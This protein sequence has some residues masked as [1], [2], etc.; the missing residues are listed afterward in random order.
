MMMMDWPEFFILD[1]GHGNCTILRD[2]AGTVIIDCPSDSTLMATLRYLNIHEIANILISHA[3]ADHIG[4]ITNLLANQDIK[5]HNVFLNADALKRTDVWQD[6]RFALKDARKR[7][8]TNV[9]VGLTTV[10]TGQ[11]NVG[12]VAIEVLAPTP[13]LAMSGAGG[14]DLDGS[15]LSSNSM[16]VVIGLVHDS[17]RVAIL[18]GDIDEIGVKNLLTEHDDLSADIL[19]FPHHGGKPGS[20][21]GEVF[22]QLLC[23]SVNP[24]L[25]LFSIDRNLFDNPREEIIRGVKSTLPNAHIM[26]T[27]LSKKC[28]AQLPE[29]EFRHLT[30]LPAKGRIDNC[31]C[32]GSISIK[33][34][35]K[36]T[37]NIPQ[38]ALHREFV[39]SKVA[40]PLC[41][42]FLSKTPV[43]L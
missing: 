2:T 7:T 38:V 14:Q 42:R 36:N 8:G 28:A 10:Q 13:E 6:L 30:N 19:V 1:V 16:S 41:L 40:T 18:P 23:R 17:H 26:C 21:D 39:M 32:A 29:A 9:Y 20:G 4:G 37:M 34:N 5:V 43:T 24:K 27:Q 31:C 15:S 25:V 22:A 33:L 12:Q 35:G 3:D 11:F